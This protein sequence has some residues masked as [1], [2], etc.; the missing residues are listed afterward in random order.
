MKVIDV[1][2]IDNKLKERNKTKLSVER[3]RNTQLNV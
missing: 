3:E 1:E 2:W